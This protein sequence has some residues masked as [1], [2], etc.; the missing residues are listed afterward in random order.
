MIGLVIDIVGTLNGLLGRLTISILGSLSLFLV[1]GQCTKVIIIEN[2]L[3]YKGILSLVV[4]E[5]FF[6]GFSLSLFIFRPSLT[7]IQ[8]ILVFTLVAIFSLVLSFKLTNYLFRYPNLTLEIV[9][10]FLADLT[11]KRVQRTFI[12]V[13]KIVT[14]LPLVAFLTFGLF[15]EMKLDNDLTLIVSILFGTIVT[16]LIVR[17]SSQTI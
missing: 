6:L 3:S 14:I 13:V 4:A 15:I 16:F 17:K 9:K 11:L 1:I 12:K 8:Y 7:P 5:L 10:R 2:K